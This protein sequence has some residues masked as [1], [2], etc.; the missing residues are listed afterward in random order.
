MAII[1]RL[2]GE[3]I[4]PFKSFDFDFSDAEGNPH[5]GPHIL[6][7]VNGSG[8]STV[9]RTLAW[10]FE[11]GETDGFRWQE[12][13]HLT[14]G[15]PTSTAMVVLARPNLAPQVIAQ[16]SDTTDG[17]DLRL[18]EWVHEKLSI[19]KIET[20]K[21]GLGHRAELWPPDKH[22]SRSRSPSGKMTFISAVAPWEQPAGMLVATYGPSRLLKH[23][24]QVSL[25][26]QLKDFRENAL[27]FEATVQNQAIQSWLVGLF[28][29]KAIARERGEN[30]DRYSTA[31][32]RF[33][34]AVR[35][36]LCDHSVGFSVDI[37][38]SLQP[39]LIMYGKR[40]DFSQL[41][42]GVRSS[43]GWLADFLM[44][45]EM[46]E[47]ESPKIHRGYALFLDEID[48]HLHPRWQ[49]SVLPSV[50]Q[51]IPGVQVFATSHS[52][53]VISSCPGARVHILDLNEAEGVARNRPAEDAPVGES[54]QATIKDIFGVSSRFDIETERLLNEWNELHRG[55]TKR[56]L[57]AKER[58][59]L[60]ELT[61][62]L[63][64]RSDELRQAVSPV[65]SINESLLASLKSQADAGE[66]R[67][68]KKSRRG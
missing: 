18:G 67:Q 1:A 33:E 39:K 23:L 29:R 30:L 40:L 6:A 11:V 13:Q 43:V 20:L 4:G 9:L 21:G 3:G 52:P 7:G 57:S 26:S 48:A 49:R 35:L 51:T 12:W 55:Q 61:H 31:L 53:F 34:S 54:I 50:K 16:T 41:P 5:P 62:V 14:Q 37:E 64:S 2:A 36:M 22:I 25:S 10:L 19:G 56:G 44:R 65:L 28:S 58:S 63:S 24:P 47:V 38:P 46:Y 15:Y 17:W 42:D 59:R 8:K 66:Q 45:M 60:A 32:E 27:S 68:K